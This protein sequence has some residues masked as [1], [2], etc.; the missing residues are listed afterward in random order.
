MDVSIIIVNYNVK[1]FIVPC[2]NS[3]HKYSKSKCKY[4]IIVVDNNSVDGSVE[5]LKNKFS[6]IKIISNNEN[7]GFSKGCNQGAR[8]CIGENILFLNP[9]TLFVEDSL[10]KLMVESKKR[11]HKGIIGPKIIDEG[12][13]VQQSFWKYPTLCNTILSLLHLDILNQRKNYKGIALNKTTKVDSIS[14]C[15]LFISKKLFN[16]L[17]G[18][19]EIFFWMEDVD[20]CLRSNKLGESVLYYPLT[21]I[22]HISGASSQKNYKLT[23]LNQLNS[24]IKF[25][26]T[27]HSKTSVIVIQF[28]ILFISMFKVISFWILSPFSKKFKKKV[29]AYLYALHNIYFK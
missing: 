8:Q 9:D 25:F 22:K 27:H 16:E 13:R 17:S 1:E 23:I 11:K 20:I 29:S 14:G 18:F 24:K 10:E 19:N 3:I 5:I 21:K 2:I 28:F 4:E 7:N 15:G 6:Q 26:K 12:G